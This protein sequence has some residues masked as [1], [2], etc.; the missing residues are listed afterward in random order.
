MMDDTGEFGKMVEVDLGESG[1]IRS[2]LLGD[3]GSYVKLTDEELNSLI[4]QYLANI[5]NNKDEKYT[6]TKKTIYDKICNKQDPTIIA[7]ILNK[8][9]ENET[10]LRE[11]NNSNELFKKIVTMDGFNDK[12]KELADSGLKDKLKL[13]FKDKI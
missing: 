7:T 9:N 2:D 6:N 12:E 11:S 13:M 3:S 5:Q 1:T 10:N 8:N 4:E